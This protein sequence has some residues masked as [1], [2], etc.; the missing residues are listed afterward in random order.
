MTNFS[1]ADPNALSLIMACQGIL[2]KINE[3]TKSE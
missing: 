3:A 2:S 1:P